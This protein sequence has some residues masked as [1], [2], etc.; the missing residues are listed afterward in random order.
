M[1]QFLGLWWSSPQQRAT[2]RFVVSFR[3]LALSLSDKYCEQT[4]WSPFD[5]RC[6]QESDWICLSIE[7]V[8]ISL[9]LLV[10]HD[11]KFS[12]TIDR[13]SIS[14][15]IYA[16]S[17]CQRHV[18]LTFKTRETSKNCT[19]T[20][21]WLRDRAQATWTSGYVCIYLHATHPFSTRDLALCQALVSHSFAHFF[22]WPLI[23]ASDSSFKMRS[24]AKNH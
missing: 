2:Y 13:P 10:C 14:H 7:K 19:D 23:C 1:Y 15:T 12:V 5:L 21:R 3:D 8:S 16:C 17:L 11:N 4:T 18:S 20:A 6:N 24:I 9:H 22:K